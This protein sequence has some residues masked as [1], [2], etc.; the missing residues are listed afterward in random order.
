MP[1]ASDLVQI[2]TSAEKAKS[3]IAAIDSGETAVETAPRPPRHAHKETPATQEEPLV[4]IETH[5]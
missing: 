4:Q 1:A 5:K 3:A 2:E